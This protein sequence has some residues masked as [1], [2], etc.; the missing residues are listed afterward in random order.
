MKKPNF[1]P[2]KNIAIKTP[3]HEYEKVSSHSAHLNM[4]IN[5]RV[6]TS[7][8]EGLGLSTSGY[9]AWLKDRAKNHKNGAERKRALAAYHDAHEH[10]NSFN[11]V[12]KVHHELTR[13][14][15]NLV[16][17]LNRRQA[18]GHHIGGVSS[19]PEGYVDSIQHKGKT[20]PSKFVLRQEFAKQNFQ[21]GKPKS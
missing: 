10:S 19:N 2:G 12:F 18:F 13:A 4:Y 6:R 5:H 9:K 11:K 8:R 16:H 20:I 1:K 7:P 15:E 21:A 17:T 3:T 14:K